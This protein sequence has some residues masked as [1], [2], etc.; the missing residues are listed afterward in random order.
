MYRGKNK[1]ECDFIGLE[2]NR[3]C[4]R[5]KECKNKCY[6]SINGLYIYIYKFCNDDLSKF[7]LLLR[8]GVYPYEYIDSRERFDETSLSDKKDFYSEL[9]LEDIIEKDYEHAQK[10]WE[11]FK[12]K[13]LGEYHDLYVQNDTL[14]ACRCI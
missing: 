2:N 1:S 3:L 6:K 4:Y 14:F 11:G 12:I 5:C 9:N 10:L 7:V 8:K 13:N